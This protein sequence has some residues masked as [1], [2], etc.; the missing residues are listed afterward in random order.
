MTPALVQTLRALIAEDF[1]FLTYDSV[2]AFH[3]WSTGAVFFLSGWEWE[4]PWQ[5]ETG[6]HMDREG[7]MYAPD[8][9]A[10]D[11]PPLPVRGV[12]IHQKALDA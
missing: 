4:G 11:W 3:Q 9:G 1:K 7:W 6:P 12:G 5:V 2:L 8:F 10:M